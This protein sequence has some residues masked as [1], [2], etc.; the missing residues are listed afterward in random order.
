MK[1]GLNSLALRGEAHVDNM[2]KYQQHVLGIVS[3]ALH[4]PPARSRAVRALLPRNRHFA[5]ARPARR[6][7]VGL[8]QDLHLEVP[9]ISRGAEYAQVVHSFKLLDGAATILKCL[10]AA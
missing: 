9:A 2:L 1:S 8:V 10:E 5:E 3:K 6:A 4:T 7:R